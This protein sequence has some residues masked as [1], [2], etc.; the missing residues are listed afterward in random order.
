MY[1]EDLNNRQ[2]RFEISLYNGI[3]VLRDRTLVFDSSSSSSTSSSS[4]SSTSSI[5]SRI[6]SCI[7]TRQE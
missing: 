2:L 7:K 5:V 4:T 3:L 6:K 1:M